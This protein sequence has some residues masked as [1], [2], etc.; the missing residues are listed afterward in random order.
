MDRTAGQPI[1]IRSHLNY[2]LT[3]PICRFSF[4]NHPSD[5]P[6]DGIVWSK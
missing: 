5:L 2:L 4:A 3:L 6:D 1:S